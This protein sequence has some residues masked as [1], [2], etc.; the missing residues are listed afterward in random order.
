MILCIEVWTLSDIIDGSDLGSKNEESRPYDEIWE[1]VVVKGKEEDEA[2]ERDFQ[3]EEDDYDVAFQ[4]Y[5]SIPK[6]PIIRNPTRDTHTSGGGTSQGYVSG[7]GK[8]PIERG[9]LPHF[10]DLGDYSI[11]V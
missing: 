3:R 10:D 5:Y 7:K 11:R 1:T 4:P 6:R 8:A 9:Q 2:I